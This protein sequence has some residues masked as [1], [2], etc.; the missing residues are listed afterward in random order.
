[1]LVHPLAGGEVGHQ[2]LVDAAR[3]TE[4]EVF[5]GGSLAQL[6]QAQPHG[7]APVAALGQFAVGEQSQALFETELPDV[8]E[9]FLL[10]ER[11][12]HAGEFQYVQFLEGRVTQ[13]RMLLL[14]WQCRN[15][16]HLGSVVIFRLH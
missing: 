7:Q 2:C 14:G 3:A 12:A 8:G 6:R 4:V 11:T 13:H 1:M 15:S 5:D 9:G 10:R 16:N